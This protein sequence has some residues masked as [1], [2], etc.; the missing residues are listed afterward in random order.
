MRKMHDFIT[1]TSLALGG[2]L[3]LA[4]QAQT[5]TGGMREQMQKICATEDPEERERLL[6]E[7]M[8]NYGK[9]DGHDAR[10]G[11]GPLNVAISAEPTDDRCEQESER[12]KCPGK[13]RNLSGERKDAG[14]D[15]DP[16]AHGD[17]A[18]QGQAVFLVSFA[19]PLVG[20]SC[21]T[22]ALRR[23]GLCRP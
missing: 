16:G 4:T 19:H 20:A 13:F 5:Q 11:E 12:G 9:D 23:S 14:T 17:G 7:H 6:Q 21:T 3:A 15:H 2:V 10:Q 1:A 18:K 8:K 22:R